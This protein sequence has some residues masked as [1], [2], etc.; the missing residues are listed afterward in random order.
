MKR[1]I[2]ALLVLGIF[3]STVFAQSTQQATK[4]RRKVLLG[5][6]G[7]VRTAER[8]YKTAHGRYG[9]LADLR[10]ARLLDALVFESDSSAATHSESEANFVP[11]S[12]TFQVTVSSD[13]QHFRAVIGETCLR[14][15]ANDMGGGSM[16]CGPPRVLP[17]ED[18][19][20]GPLISLPG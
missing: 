12:T 19:P 8:N 10:K 3:V 18:G 14:V 15:E 4:D 7:I 11:K 1:L 2:G 16:H 13:R 5:W 20:E 17:L 9:D 6:L